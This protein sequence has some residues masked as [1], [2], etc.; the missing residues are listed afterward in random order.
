MP[1]SSNEK[2]RESGLNNADKILLPPLV[3]TSAKIVKADSHLVVER[4]KALG[5]SAKFATHS[6]STFFNPYAKNKA[7][8][9]KN[10]PTCTLI[11]EGE[12]RAIM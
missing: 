4:T 7:D 3:V 10:K 5:Y 1:S 11:A 9:D 2:N 8:K 6:M 12:E